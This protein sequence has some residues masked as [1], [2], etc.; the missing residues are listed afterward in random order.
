[1]SPNACRPIAVASS[2]ALLLVGCVIPIPSGYDSDS[3]ENIADAAPV[4]IE[5]GATTREDVLMLLGEPDAVA[6]D[7]SW[8]AYTSSY[9]SGGLF[10]L[11]GA[12]G[13]IA[14]MGGTRM[15]YRRLIVEFDTNGKTAALKFESKRCFEF[16]ASDLTGNGQAIGTKPCLDV[17]GQDIPEKLHLPALRK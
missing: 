6:L 2:A 7:E 9:T 13:G 10:I 17:R 8:I 14:A 4:T 11:A 3:R 5:V 1:M 16:G 12:G 15:R